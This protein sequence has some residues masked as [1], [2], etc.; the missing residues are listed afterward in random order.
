[1]SKSLYQDCSKVDL[2]RN[3]QAKQLGR[4]LF[5]S[6]CHMSSSFCCG[7]VPT[8]CIL[9]RRCLPCKVENCRDC[10]E[11]WRL[12]GFYHKEIAQTLN[13]SICGTLVQRIYLNAQVLNIGHCCYVRYLLSEDLGS[14]GL[15][16]PGLG[17]DSNGDLD[18]NRF[19]EYYCVCLYYYIYIYVCLSVYLFFCLSVCNVTVTV[20]VA[21]AVAVTVTVT[22]LYVCMPV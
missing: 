7:S 6:A 16:M 13:H 18:A 4:L 8:S 5:Q 2:R 11:D 15:C 14:C 20:T 19:T 10:N 1:M 12:H 3:S 21:V 22:V 9:L 17:L